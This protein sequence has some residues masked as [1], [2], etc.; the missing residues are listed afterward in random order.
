[1][2]KGRPVKRRKRGNN[3]GS[4]I[5]EKVNGSSYFRIKVTMPDGKSKYK[6]LKTLVEAKETLLRMRAEMASGVMPSDMT[7]DEWSEH[8]LSTRRGLKPKTLNQYTYNLAVA[9]SFFGKKKLAKLSPADIE[10]MNNSLLDSGLSSTYVRQMHTN[11]GTCLKR[12]YKRGLIA[13][14]ICSLVDAP[15]AMKRIPVMLSS[16]QHETLIDAS[17]VSPR[18]LIVEFTLMTGMRIG[19][20]LSATWSQIDDT[21]K[22]V[23]VVD[24]KTEA[25]SGREIH[26]DSH[27]MRRLTALR[28]EHRTIQ[29]E[30]RSS[31]N[32]DDFVFCTS[33]GKNNNR[34]NLQ[35]RVLTPLLKEAEL[36]HLTW[37]HLRHNAG[38]YWLSKNV[39]ITVV[40]ETLGHANP[41]ITMGIYA[42]VLR[43]D[44]RQIAE[45]SEAL[46]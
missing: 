6:R 16:Q 19:E 41:A 28:A 1:M 8:Y 15:K 45:V 35:R 30:Q 33:E 29:L 3:E 14:D 5:K 38:S 27:L 22:V 4:I 11:V 37:H 18:E 42:H 46:G 23:T 39:P 36:P 34:Q 32:S 40:S 9:S 31:W 2:T 12:A 21:R 20:V 24:S 44:K 25:G 26:M 10:V 13:K 43:E 17:R 7:F